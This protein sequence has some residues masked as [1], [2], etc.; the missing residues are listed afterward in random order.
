[1]TRPNPRRPQELW[2]SVREVAAK[3]RVSPKSIYRAVHRGE[4]PTVRVGRQF[5][6]SG[7]ALDAYIRAAGG[8]PR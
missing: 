8:G 2:L 5:R 3:L 7:R 6:I 1:M 4:L